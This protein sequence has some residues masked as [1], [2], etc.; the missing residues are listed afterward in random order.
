MY[1]FLK[2]IVMSTVYY[3]IKKIS[4]AVHSDTAT[5]W[6]TNVVSFSHALFKGVNTE[7]QTI[8]DLT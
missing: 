4:L 6:V 2:F 8:P 5:L 1:T 7:K 3:V